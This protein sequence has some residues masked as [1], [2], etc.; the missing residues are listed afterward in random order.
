MLSCAQL[1][2]NCITYQCIIVLFYGFIIT[3]SSKENISITFW[4]ISWTRGSVNIDRDY[5]TNADEKNKWHPWPK[6]T[7]HPFHVGVFNPRTITVIT[8]AN[9]DFLVFCYNSRFAPPMCNKISPWLLKFMHDI[10]A[11]QYP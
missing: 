11:N 8:I 1:L 9:S 10:M 2:I 3:S 7:E 6:G 4:A 5:E